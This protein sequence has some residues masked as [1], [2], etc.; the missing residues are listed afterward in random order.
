MK[1]EISIPKTFNIITSREAKDMLNVLFQTAKQRGEAEMKIG[2]E[3][4][5][6]TSYEIDANWNEEFYSYLCLKKWT[7]L[8]H[9]YSKMKILKILEENYNLN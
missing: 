6:R 3:H 4:Y 2:K 9:K 7:Y 8:L 5:I 1:I